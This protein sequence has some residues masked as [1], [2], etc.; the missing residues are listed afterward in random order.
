MPDLSDD[1]IIA[2][3][4]RKFRQAAIAGFISS[5]VLVGFAVMM[6][7]VQPDWFYRYQLL[8]PIVLIV[9]VFAAWFLFWRP[10]PEAI[11]DRI[12]KKRVDEFQ[13][14]YRLFLLG[15][16]LIVGNSLLNAPATADQLNP[17][18]FPPRPITLILTLLAFASLIAFGF[19]SL[20]RRF[21]II[22]ND[23]LARELRFRVSRLGYLLLVAG[24]CAAYLA[25]LYRPD[26]LSSVLRGAL[27]A[28]LAVPALVYV[29]LE[30]RASG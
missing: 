28:G 26:L 19:G 11:S 22:R 13:G 14:R 6:W 30:W 8:V 1:E 17:G 21:D 15:G 2:C 27:F 7:N 16:V 3:E 18:I 9:A 10:A 24:L 23:E 4:K 5:L 25:L 20:R 29:I 12:L